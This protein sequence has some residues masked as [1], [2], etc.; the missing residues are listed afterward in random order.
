M[1]L[2]T[3]ADVVALVGE[4]RSLVRR[5]LRALAS[6]TKPGLRALMA[7]SRVDQAKVNE[8]SVAFALAPRLNAA[9]RLYRA[10]AGL[11]LILT[12]DR[13]ACPGDR[14]RSSTAPTASAGRWRSASASRPKPRS[15]S[16]ASAP[17][18]AGRRG[19]ASRG[20]RHRRLAPGRAPPPPGRDDLAGG[21]DRQGIGPRSIEAFDLLAGL[22]ACARAPARLRR[23]PRRRRPRDRARSAGGVRRRAVRPR[24]A[25]SCEPGDMVAVE[26]V[27][28][29]VGGDEL[30]MTLA[31]ELQRLAPFG[32]G[33]PGVS[34]LVADATFHDGRP[35]GEGKHVRFTVESHGGAGAGGG[36]RHRRA[37]AGRRRRPGRGHV[38]ARDQRVERAS[39][40]SPGAARGP[41]GSERRSP[42]RPARGGSR[43]SRPSEEL[44]LFALDPEIAFNPGGRSPT[45]W[46]WRSPRIR[47][48]RPG[49]RPARAPA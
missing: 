18:R 30:G 23:P 42:S 11:E 20:D 49:P 3:I 16:W 43:G 10:D 39:R 24:R 47:R 37:A 44:V 8:R 28:A 21:R 26:R 27:D 9:G 1:A 41:P 13:G 38:H 14:R 36:V 19:V 25:R 5:G 29:V 34:L 45:L 17:L 15:P 48:V 35:M 32:R 2:A 6:T 31:E 22:T 7:V 4:N 12:E 40:T 46:G 33:N